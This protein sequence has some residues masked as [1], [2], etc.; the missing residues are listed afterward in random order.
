ME[1]Y[2]KARHRKRYCKIFNLKI[3]KIRSTRNGEINLSNQVTYAVPLSQLGTE[4]C[5]DTRNE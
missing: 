1:E 5:Y 2:I 3:N 4:I